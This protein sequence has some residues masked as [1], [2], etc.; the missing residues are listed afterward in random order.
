MN[1]GVIVCLAFVILFTL[2]RG[3]FSILGEKATIL[4]SGFNL[5]SKDER[6]KYDI[7]KMSKDYRKSMIIWIVTLLIGA[8]GSYYISSYCSVLAFVIWLII[9]FKDIHLDEE[10]AFG[11]YKINK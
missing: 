10:K 9:F 8:I 2:I 1:I 5:K 4:I 7:E 11:K 6:E 3:I